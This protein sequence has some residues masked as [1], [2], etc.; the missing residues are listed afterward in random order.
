MCLLLISAY[1]LHVRHLAE[2]IMITKTIQC[3]CHGVQFLTQ[4]YQKLFG[5]RSPR[6][7]AGF[8]G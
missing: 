4:M 8:K 3:N 2:L 6:P 5:G 1:V 7:L